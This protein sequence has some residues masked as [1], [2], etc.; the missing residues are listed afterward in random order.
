MGRASLPPP[1]TPKDWS[2]Q[3]FADCG[4]RTK[5]GTEFVLRKSDGGLELYKVVDGKAAPQVM[6]CCRCQVSHDHMSR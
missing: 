2:G 3:F 4:T 6:E 5:E 1:T